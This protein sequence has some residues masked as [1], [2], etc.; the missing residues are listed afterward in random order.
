M[1]VLGKENVKWSGKVRNFIMENSGNPT[2]DS[3][4]RT[5]K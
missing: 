2:I 4:K 3:A 1:S 5:V